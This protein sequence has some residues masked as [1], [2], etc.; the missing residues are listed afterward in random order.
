[1]RERKRLIRLLIT[2]VTLTRGQDTITAAIRFPAGRHHV[3]RLP[4]P[5]NAWQLRATPAPL[6][7]LIDH[8]LDNCT[9]AQI[10]GQLNAAGHTSSDGHP[11]DGDRVAKLANYHQMPSHDQRLCDRGLLSLE[12]VANDLGAHPS[13]IKRWHRLGL[14]TGEQADDRGIFRYHPGQ[15]RPASADAENARKRLGNDHRSGRRN[16]HRQSGRPRTP[17]ENVR[18]PGDTE[19]TSTTTT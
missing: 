1:M 13:S 9:Y 17:R 10:A 8:L 6:T 16:P 19:T 3:L 15:T 18:L 12:Q 4:V 2:D 14:I 5:K 7:E 11:W